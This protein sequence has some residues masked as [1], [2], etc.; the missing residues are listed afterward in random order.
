MVP[1]VSGGITKKKK[2]TT[3]Y[4]NNHLLSIQFHTAKEFPFPNPERIYHRF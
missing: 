2:W 4:P 3:V 1:P